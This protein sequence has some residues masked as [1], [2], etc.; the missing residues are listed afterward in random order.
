[1]RLRKGNHKVLVISDLQV[2]FHHPDAFSFL[3]E[4]KKDIKPTQIVCIGDSI[5][6]YA[7]GSYVRD[8]DSMSAGAEHRKAK[9]ALKR[10]YDLFPNAIEVD[11][12]HNNRVYRRAKEAGI[13]KTFLK[14][15]AELLD[16]PWKFTERTVIDEVIYEHGDAFGGQ[17]PHK[18][19]TLSNTKSTVIGHHH[20]S[21]GIQYVST[22]ER[23]LFGMNVGCLIDNS[24]YAFEY[25]KKYKFHPTLACGAVLY[26]VPKLIP[27]ITGPKGRWSRELTV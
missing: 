9:E 15:Y 11:S 7:L 8:P 16:S 13:P 22:R 5:D 24:A 26:G 21:S 4:I 2:P 20:C 19:A 6:A 10:L 14:D 3:E 25:N 17:T 18:C 27:M 12:N 23:M 1:M